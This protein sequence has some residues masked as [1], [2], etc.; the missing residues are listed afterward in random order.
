M[1]RCKHCGSQ[2]REYRD[3]KGLHC[4][5][6][7]KTVESVFNVIECPRCNNRVVS[8]KSITNARKLWNERNI[9][10]KQDMYDKIVEI[11]GAWFDNNTLEQ[12]RV[13]VKLYE[14]KINEAS[15]E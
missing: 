7:G 15:N 11:L 6:D 9:V 10:T 8:Y 4:D 5:L 3:Q 2:H 13:C 14:S 12:V 1:K